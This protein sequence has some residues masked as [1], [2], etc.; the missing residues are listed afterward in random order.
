M[1]ESL[2]TAT[3]TLFLHDVEAH[4]LHLE[5]Q[6]QAIIKAGQLVKMHSSEKISPCAA[7]DAENIII[8][9]ALTDAAAD[10]LVTV[11]VRGYAVIYAKSSAATVAGPVEIG[12]YTSGFNTFTTASAVAKTAGW[13]LDAAAGAAEIIRVLIKD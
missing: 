3:Q 8:G 1:P 7:G 9:I 12:A 11:G 4:K 13:S 5:F 10:E 2:G 6:A